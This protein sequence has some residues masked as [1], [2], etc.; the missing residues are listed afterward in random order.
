M[1]NTLIDRKYID[2]G[3]YFAVEDDA[4]KKKQLF[5]KIKEE[6]NNVFRQAK[7]DL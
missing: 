1:R 6:I 3:S 4:D 5:D 7:R 2:Q